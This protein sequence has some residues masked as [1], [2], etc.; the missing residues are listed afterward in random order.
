MIFND[1]IKHFSRARINRYWIATNKSKRKTIKLYKANLEIS[2]AFHPLLGMVEV[3]LRNHLN[4]RLSSYFNDSDWIINQKSGFMADPSLTYVQKHTRKKVTNNFLKREVQKVEDRLRKSDIPITSGKII[5]EQ[6]FGFWTDLFEVHHYKLLKGK[7]IQIFKGLPNNYGRKEIMDDLT[8][9]RRFRNRINHNEPI[10]FVGNCI[11]FTE[12][13]QVYTS[14]CNILKWI[15]P[16]L[17]K[18]MKEFD[19]V[20]KSINKAIKI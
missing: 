3:V 19:V 18:I 20:Q 15:D 8:K 4:E 9:I 17:I 2:Q 12:T 5:A 11:D 13:I 6:T 1:F 10:C 16:Q 7:P 14:I